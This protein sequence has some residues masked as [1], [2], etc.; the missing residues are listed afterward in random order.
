MKSILKLSKKFLLLALM[1]VLPINSFAAVS[2]SDGSA[3]ISKSEFSASLNNLS[4]RIATIENT[5][6]AKIDS[7]V[8][9]YLSRNG[10]WN[11]EIQDLEKDTDLTKTTSGGYTVYTY[12]GTLADL[13]TSFLWTS[14]TL[15]AFPTK[16]ASISNKVVINKISKSG[17]IVMPTNLR[18]GQ[19]GSIAQNRILPNSTLNGYETLIHRI[20]DI[21]NNSAQGFQ[22]DFSPS[23]S[24]AMIMNIGLNSSED[25]T[26]SDYS[27]AFD[28]SRKQPIYIP[29][30][31]SSSHI[32]YLP[33]THEQFDMRGSYPL[34]FNDIINNVVVF[35]VNKGQQLVFNFEIYVTTNSSSTAFAI[36]G[37]DNEYN[38]VGAY[39][40][41]NIQGAIAVGWE[42]VVVY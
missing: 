25:K 8:S 36:S 33:L 10:I 26:M 12:G 40:K 7:L 18:I 9:S 17:M 30:Q 6:D 41:T 5:L 4:N 42:K 34:G 22:G 27:Q 37:V 24:I 3:F 23:G 35:F 2:V 15:N 32:K 11:G 19:N 13:F 28:I 16:V 29:M 38:S 20:A 31:P 39:V 21:K 14:T 1:I